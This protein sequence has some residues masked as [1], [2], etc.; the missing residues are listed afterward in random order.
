MLN[1]KKG[2]VWMNDL[3]KVI[4]TRIHEY[5]VRN[6][7]SVEE[8]SLLLGI[9]PAFLRL[10]ERGKRGTKIENLVTICQY[11]KI[12]TDDMLLADDELFEARFNEIDHTAKDSLMVNLIGLSEEEIKFIIEFVKN[13]KELKKTLEY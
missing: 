2:E 6:N 3:K 9:S 12:S 13:Y 4:G 1:F 8:L 10:V 5:R 11:F 7:V